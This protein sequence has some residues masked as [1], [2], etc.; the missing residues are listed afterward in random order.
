MH[1]VLV[2]IIACGTNRDNCIPPPTN[3]FVSQK[4]KKTTWL[5]RGVMVYFI[6]I[7]TMAR[8]VFYSSTKSGIYAN[9]IVDFHIL[10]HFWRTTKELQ[11]NVHKNQKDLK[12]IEQ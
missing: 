2:Y 8:V 3:A 10:E 1:V 6:Y 11:T 4:S 7:A 5:T 9:F 12:N